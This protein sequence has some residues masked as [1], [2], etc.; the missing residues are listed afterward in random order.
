MSIVLAAVDAT[1]AAKA[2]LETAI[3]IGRLTGCDVAAVHVRCDALESV[4]TPKSLAAQV[5]VP[6]RV[7]EGSVKPVLLE[8]LGAS[9]VIV[10]VVGARATSGSRRPVGRTAAHIIEHLD[11]PVVLVPPEVE[12]P[13]SIRRILVPLEVPRRRVDRCASNCVRSWWPRPR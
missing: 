6:F 9:D 4:H 7:F 13:I 8:A 11:K 2:V 3:Q 5:K 10:A 1:P 12:P